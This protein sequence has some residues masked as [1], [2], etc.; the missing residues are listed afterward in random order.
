VTEEVDPLKRGVPKWGIGGR[1]E[2]AKGNLEVCKRG[3]HCAIVIVFP[4]IQYKGFQGI[5][6]T[7]KM[8]YFL[9]KK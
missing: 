3:P 7:N 5:K 8:A 1:G 6:G 2:A 9:L 4:R